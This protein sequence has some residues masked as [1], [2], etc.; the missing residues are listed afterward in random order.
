[1]QLFHERFNLPAPKLQN[2][3]DRQKLRLSFRNERHLHK[4]KC[5]L[6]GKDIISTYPA[7]TLFPVY[8][9]EAWWSDAW[10]PLAFGVDFDFK[11]TF[12]EN[13]KI[14]QNKT[15]RMALNAQNVTNSDYANYCCDAKNCYIVYGSIVVED[16]YYGSPYYSKDCVDN[17][18]LRHSELCYECI[19]S[20][21]LYNCDWL[22]DSENCRD[23]KYG[24]DLKNCHDCVFCVGIRGASYHIFNKP[25]SKEEYLVRIKNMD[26]KK[27]SSLDFNNFEMLKM[28][29]PRQF[30]IGAH[31][32]N[33]VGNYLFHCKNVF[34][35]FNAER[36]EDCAYLGQV[37]DCKDCQ[38]VNYMEN[39]EL[40]YD[41]F[42]FYNNYMVW[43]CNTAGN[44]KFMQYCEFCANSKYL[45][46]CISVKNNEYCIF[47]KKYSQLEFEKLQAKIIDHM[48]ETGE[49][50]NYL[51]KSLVLFKY[52]DTAANDYFRK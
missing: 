11:K 2:P 28:R 51:D 37:M 41:S 29:M 35:S 7:G 16:C 17:T 1:M 43:F 34:E 30:M 38:D 26:L 23:C 25:Y 42:G 13:F 49:Y 46:G 45:F 12:T 19:D 22:Q 5:D 18:I 4:R 10:D 24:Y 14:L 40:C 36:C 47:N 50:G 20:E 27:P 44:G 21:K 31:N 52:E 32:E 33:V 9:K 3:L 15:P 39:S 6:T 48:K 8:Q